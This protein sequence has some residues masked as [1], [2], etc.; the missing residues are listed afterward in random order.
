[1]IANL[2]KLSFLDD[3]R[4]ALL[5]DD[6]VRKRAQ[7]IGVYIARSCVGTDECSLSYSAFSHS[8]GLKPLRSY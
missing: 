3:W 4:R 7:L 1:M 2:L 5:A 8:N 6:T